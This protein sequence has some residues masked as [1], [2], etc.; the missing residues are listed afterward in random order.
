MALG[1]S[2]VLSHRSA[3][4]LWELLPWWDRPVDVSLPSRSGRLRRPGILIHR[5]LSLK[6]AET[7]RRR[8]IPVTT[9]ARTLT[10]L[11]TAVS[12]HEL[13]RAIRQ[14]DFLGLPTGPDAEVDRTRSELER[15]FL[16]L[17]HRHRLSKPAVNIR[18]GGLTVDF[19][20]VEQQLIVETDGYSS[21]RGR[22]AFEDDR[23]RDLKLRALGYEV[24]RLSHRQ[25]FSE[26]TQVATVLRAALVARWG[27]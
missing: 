27:D 21:H 17:C 22:T 10:D 23:D 11:R 18:I 2:A 6:P 1:E 25:I 7:T 15:R 16:W 3:A 19:C 20:W 24:L 4:E 13:R 5:P 9:P 12:A 8:G 14:A 26:P